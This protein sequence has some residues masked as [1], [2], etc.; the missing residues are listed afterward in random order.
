[1]AKYETAFKLKGVIWRRKLDT[2]GVTALEGWKRRRPGMN[3]T[4]CRQVPPSTAA[5]D[6]TRIPREEN[7]RLCTEVAY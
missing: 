1:M 3:P 5:T 6:T 2:G 7:E 4:R